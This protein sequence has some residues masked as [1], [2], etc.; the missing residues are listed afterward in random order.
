MEV[1]G[2]GQLSLHLLCLNYFLLADFEKFKESLA[3]CLDFL[4]LLVTFP[5]FLFFILS[6]LVLRCISRRSFGF[7]VLLDDEKMG[8]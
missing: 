2:K 7:A 8:G 1:L 6:L 3:L 4:L 5:L